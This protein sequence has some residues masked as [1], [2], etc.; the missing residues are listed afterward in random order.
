MDNVKVCRLRRG[1][2]TLGVITSGRLKEVWILRD[3][4]EV[5]RDATADDIP[6]AKASYD[7]CVS[8][9]VSA[10]KIRN[11]REKLD[12]L[13]MCQQLKNAVRH[14]E[15]SGGTIDKLI[16]ARHYPVMSEIALG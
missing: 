2:I 15:N 10:S 5:C 1:G 11:A 13:Y 6:A 3:F 9:G 12:R 7:E 16:T 4:S 14:V 8:S